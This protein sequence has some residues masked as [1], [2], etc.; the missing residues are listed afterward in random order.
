MVSSA[1]GPDI[2][3]NLGHTGINDGVFPFNLSGPSKC[4]PLGCGG[5]NDGATIFVELDSVTH[6]VTHSLSDTPPI[7]AVSRYAA[8]A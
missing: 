6:S 7:E 1:E 8:A 5:I 2:Y 3:S 4:S